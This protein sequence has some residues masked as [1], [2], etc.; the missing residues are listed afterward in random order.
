MKFYFQLFISGLINSQKAK[1]VLLFIITTFTLHPGEKIFAQNDSSNF[2]WPEGNHVALSL[3]FDDARESQVIKGTALLDQYGVKATF[4]V[5]PSSVEKQLDGWKKAAA[6]G[7]EIGNHS[8][9]HPCTGNFAWSRTNALEDYTLEQMRKQLADCN[10]R[11]SE[12]LNVKAEVFAY[13]C[14]Q[15]Y[16]GRGV[17]TQSY[18]PIVAD[19]FLAGRGWLDE[20]P[21]DPKYCNFAQLTGVEM[22]GKDFEQILPLIEEAKK[23]SQWLLLAGHEMDDSGVQTTRLSML[24]KLIEYAQNPAN[25]VWLQPVGTVAK[26]IKEHEK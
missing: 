11:I 2:I 26:Y 4:Y 25:G 23:T 18:V 6:S 14:G 5:V 3:S 7:H 22:D 12:L 1:T 8:L 24:K 19:M 10:K 16:V 15:K 17:N 20:A 21:N 9:T 13:P